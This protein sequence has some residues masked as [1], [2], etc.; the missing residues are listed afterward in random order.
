MVRIRPFDSS[1]PSESCTTFNVSQDAMYLATS[2][3]HYV[4][5]MNVY[6][7]SDSLPD[8][9]M[10]HALT[11]LVVRVEKLEDDRWGVAIQTFSS[12]SSMTS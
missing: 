7:S 5:G 4:P 2:S 3:G 10:D 9:L 1:L 6:V 11:G 12:T 8:S